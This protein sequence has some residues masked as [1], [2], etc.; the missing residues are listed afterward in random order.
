MIVVEHIVHRYPDG[1]GKLVEALSLPSATF[2]DNSVWGLV[3]PS[4]SGKSTL[5]HCISGVLRPTEGSIQVG[6]APLENM[7][8][9]ELARW[10]GEQV[11][12][13][14]QN[15]NLL[16]ALTVRDNIYLGTYFAGNT[17]N[18]KE[19][20]IKSDIETLAKR[21]QIE[22]LLDKKPKQLSMGEQQRVAI[23]RALIKKPEIVLADE[24]TANLDAHNSAIVMELL[25]EYQ[26]ESK[27]TLLV[28]T[29]DRDV[30]DRLPNILSLEKPGGDYAL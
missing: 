2:A 4:G 9:N 8:E 21:L 20:N 6:E 23:A 5:L 25:E 22:A 10:R 7:S 13:V 12:Y 15:F 16:E 1:Q 29:H 3:G 11:G 18:E 30:M 14:F 19:S 26:R 28:A 27:I 17:F 24:P